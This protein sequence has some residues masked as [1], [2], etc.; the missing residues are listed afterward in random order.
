MQSRASASGIQGVGK[1]AA[2]TVFTIG[3]RD[4]AAQVRPVD[5]IRGAAGGVQDRHVAAGVRQEAVQ[6]GGRLV[7]VLVDGRLVRMRLVRPFG[8]L[9]CA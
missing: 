2:R 3:N 4:V 6:A 8:G 5:G 7:A 1:R 9:A